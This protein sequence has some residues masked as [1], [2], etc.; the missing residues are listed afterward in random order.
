MP[1]N[2]S[3]AW[4]D[5]RKATVVMLRRVLYGVLMDKNCKLHPLN[6]GLKQLMANE[7]ITGDL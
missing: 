5:R 1:V 4:R 3:R 7:T 6:E 2:I